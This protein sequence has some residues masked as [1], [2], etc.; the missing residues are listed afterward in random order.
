MILD[1]ESLYC[2]F[3]GYIEDCE[4]PT[5]PF[6]KFMVKKGYTHFE[7]DV[8]EFLDHEILQD[9]HE[10]FEFNEELH[11]VFDGNILEVPIKAYD[12]IITKKYEAWLTLFIS[13]DYF[14]LPLIGEAIYSP[15]IY[16]SDTDKTSLFIAKRF[17][18]DATLEK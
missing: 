12:Q 10:S 16:Y 8:C 4:D 7:S 15:E 1:K 5:L 13:A 17:I 3:A 14:G 2:I 9:L 6:E 18:T 11:A